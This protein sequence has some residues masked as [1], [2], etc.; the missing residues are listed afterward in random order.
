MGTLAVSLNRLRARL[1][2]LEVRGKKRITILAAVQRYGSAC[3]EEG[4]IR[5]AEEAKERP[6]IRL[7]KVER[8]HLATTAA[9]AIFGAA[10]RW[11]Q[12]PDLIPREEM[13]ARIEAMV[14]PNF[15]S[16]SAS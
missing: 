4:H 12:T 16:A 6:Q 9:W 14:K 2:G 7:H 13:A 10:S 3:G 15:L 5:Q 8:R 11:Y 1:C